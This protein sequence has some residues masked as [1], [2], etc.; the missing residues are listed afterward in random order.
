MIRGHSLCKEQE[1]KVWRWNVKSL[2]SALS[3]L[4]AAMPRGT[5]IRL[6]MFNV[7]E[8]STDGGTANWKHDPLYLFIFRIIV[9][10]PLCSCTACFLAKR[11]NY[12]W[13]WSVQGIQPICV[14]ISE[15]KRLLSPSGCHSNLEKLTFLT[16]RTRDSGRTNDLM[17]FW[18]VNQ[19]AH[20]LCPVT[21]WGP[22]RLC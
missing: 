1:M 9:Y 11:W 13:K 5:A 12:G 15:N 18:L 16:A 4:L 2:F 17:H 10:R 19:R 3:V 7:I 14:S 21:I 8:V 22:N 20:L 6:E